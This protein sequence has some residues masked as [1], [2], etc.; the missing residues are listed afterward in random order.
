MA[1]PGFDLGTARILVTNDD[2]IHAPGIEVLERI[3]R[4]LSADVWTVAPDVE[5]SGTSHSLTLRRPLR[6][7]K[8]GERRYSV[9]GTP[10]DCALLAINH[11]LKDRRPDLVLSGVNGGANLGEDVTY[12][13]TIAAAMES[14]LL[15]VPSIALSQVNRSL[16]EPPF[17][18]AERHGAE[19][20]RKLVSVSWPVG[21]LMNVNFPDTPVSGIC[22]GRQGRRISTI[23]LIE[24]R[25]PKNRPYVWIGD[26]TNDETAEPDTDLDA[27][28]HGAI[29]V[30]PLHL[31][32]THQPSIAL[33]R[34]LFP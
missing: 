23:E 12:S 6:L 2:G 18:I 3:A 5:Q 21:V 30:T 27:V 9:D 26:F 19:V 22:V 25:D 10:T 29:A 33:L 20:I 11:V 32:L 17:A 15:G 13:G 34:D 28:M 8:Y 24:G 7:R 1:R 31:D 16:G 4:S 14:T